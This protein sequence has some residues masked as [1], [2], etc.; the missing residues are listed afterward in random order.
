MSKF[1]MTSPLLCLVT[2]PEVPDLIQAVERALA[3]GITMLQ[4]RG[5]TLPPAHLYMLAM[6]LCP[7]CQKYQAAFIV[8]DR[9]DVGLVAG[10]NGF[11]LGVR[12]LPLPIVRQLVGEEYLLGAS[13]HSPEEAQVAVA[14]GADFLLA[15]TIF[16][17]QSHPGG[18]TGGLELLRAIKHMR[19]NCP[20]L[21][22][23]GIT[24]AN[25]GQVMDSGADGIAVI[26]VILDAA[27]IEHAV[28][29]LRTSIGL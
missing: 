25:A 6:A 19:L 22:I 4:L 23:G 13:V 7:L 8:N 26:S 5:Q 18:R 3:A 17:S 10:A 27:N 9:V 2:D 16:A 29:E 14:S 21:A 15:G 20:L 1:Q 12:S 28:R 11:Q 24:S